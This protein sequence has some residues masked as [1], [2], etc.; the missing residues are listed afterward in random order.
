MKASERV[1]NLIRNE[2]KVPI[3]TVASGKDGKQ[4]FVSLLGQMTSDHLLTYANDLGIEY[5]PTAQITQAVGQAN[6]FKLT[7]GSKQGIRDS[8]AAQQRAGLDSFVV[9]I[10]SGN[11]A[12]KGF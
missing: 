11:E 12:G 3:A 5:F 6:I 9:P 1:D 10:V 2:H 4:Y 8:I 7:E